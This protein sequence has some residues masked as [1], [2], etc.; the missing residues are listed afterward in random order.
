VEARKNTQN[1]DAEKGGRIG[2][3]AIIKSARCNL[4]QRGQRLRRD[5]TQRGHREGH[6]RDQLLVDDAVI[7]FF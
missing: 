3:V 2:S 7:L 5:G 4:L 6:E 1:R